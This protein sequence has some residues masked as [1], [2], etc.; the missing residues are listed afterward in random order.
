MCRSGCG[1]DLLCPLRFIDQ[2][3]HAQFQRQLPACFAVALA[4]HV[5]LMPTLL[6]L[7]ACASTPRRS[8][9]PACPT[10]R[11]LPLLHSPTTWC[12]LPSA[13]CP[14]AVPAHPTVLTYRGSSCRAAGQ[15]GVAVAVQP[16]TVLRWR[17]AAVC[18]QVM[19]VAADAAHKVTGIPEGYWVRLSWVS[20]QLGGE[21]YWPVAAVCGRLD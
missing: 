17:K 14:A 1:L 11:A 10:I 19:P 16:S 20:S 21:V 6:G 18:M 9:A 13:W 3:G 5:P 8:L 15:V 2:A 7:Q 12:E 4:R